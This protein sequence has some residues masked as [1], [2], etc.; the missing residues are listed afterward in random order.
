MK[1]LLIPI[2]I[3]LLIS[4]G[5]D[6]I[7][8]VNKTV[9]KGEYVIEIVNRTTGDT[10]TLV[11]TDVDTNWDPDRGLIWLGTDDKLDGKP[12]G[13][14]TAF[15]SVDYSNQNKSVEVHDFSISKTDVRKGTADELNARLFRGTSFVEK[16]HQI[17]IGKN[18]IKAYFYLTNLE[19]VIA[20]TG[21]EPEQA[22]VFGVFVAK[23]K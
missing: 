20:N 4:C 22:D 13:T 9:T 19:R 23:S 1:R 5:T 7:D 2:S 12:I 17:E 21:Q 15:V 11:G 8:P 10:T 14:V 18:Y 3:I 6:N 16:W